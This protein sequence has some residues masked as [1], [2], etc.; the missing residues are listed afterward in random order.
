MVKYI[1]FLRSI[2]VGGKNIIRMEELRKIF[3]SLGFSDVKTYIQSGNIIFKGS[4]KKVNDIKEKIESGLE[5]HF[6][7]HVDAMVR[8]FD[9]LQNMVKKSPF[10]KLIVDQDTKFYVCFFREETD[11]LPE[12]PLIKPKEGLNLIKSGKKEAWVIS[13][14]TGKMFGFPNNFIEKEFGVVSTARNWNTIVKMVNRESDN[15]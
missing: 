14:R 1:A 13:Y 4:E 6:G 8:K 3:A 10:N 7:H 15:R 5:R 2:N 12:L 11:R 9:E